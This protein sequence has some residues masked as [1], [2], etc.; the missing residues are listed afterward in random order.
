MSYQKFKYEKKGKT[1]VFPIIPDNSFFLIREIIRKLEQ[2][3]V[4]NDDER[5]NCKRAFQSS[6]TAYKTA[7]EGEGFGRS[8]TY[9]KLPTRIMTAFVCSGPSMH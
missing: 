4:R 9:F 1:A 2:Q 8:Y 7:G 6:G 3:E 5:K